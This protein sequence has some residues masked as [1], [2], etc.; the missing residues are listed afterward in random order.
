MKAAGDLK[1]LVWD[2]PGG[3]M[4]VG[5]KEHLWMANIYRLSKKLEGRHVIV[6]SVLED[7]VEEAIKKARAYHVGNP[8]RFSLT[9]TNQTMVNL[10]SEL[11]TP[12]SD[13]TI[14]EATIATAAASGSWERSSRSFYDQSQLIGMRTQPAPTEGESR[15]SAQG[16]TTQRAR[17]WL[18]NREQEKAP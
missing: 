8:S 16:D 11:A 7:C 5:P 12:S 2:L 3:A 15:P 10:A 9:L 13:L 4:W 1:G 18:R 17:E 14:Q 6:A